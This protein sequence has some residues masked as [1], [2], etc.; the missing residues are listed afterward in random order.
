MKQF[1]ML[2]KKNITLLWN[3]CF[4][5]AIEKARKIQM[6][7]WAVSVTLIAERCCR[8]H[9]GRREYI[10]APTFRCTRSNWRSHSDWSDRFPCRNCRLRCQ[11]HSLASPRTRLSLQKQHS[12][13]SQDTKLTLIFTFHQLYMFIYFNSFIFWR[14]VVHLIS[15]TQPT[16]VRCW[17]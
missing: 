8:H 5:I 17:F 7:S 2:L 12:L 10:R 14:I 16:Q 6:T 3:I 4:V 11:Q 15:V 9:R 1:I 13:Q